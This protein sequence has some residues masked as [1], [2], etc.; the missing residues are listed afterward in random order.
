MPTQAPTGSTSGLEDVTAILVR[1]PASRA[2]P[3]ILT[4]PSLISGTSCSKSLMTRSGSRRD[5]VICGPLGDS[6]TSVISTLSRS[7]MR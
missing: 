3:M 4:M 2:T 1:T 5:R 6:R 7:P